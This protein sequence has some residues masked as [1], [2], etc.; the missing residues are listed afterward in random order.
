MIVTVIVLVLFCMLSA[1]QS[2]LSNGWSEFYCSGDLCVKYKASDRETFCRICNFEASYKKID[3][4][5][6][7]AVVPTKDSKCELVLNSVV[8]AES[9]RLERR[10]DLVV[11]E[12]KNFVGR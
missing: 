10:Y 7:V 8:Q 11:V 5:L 4:V 3:S 2:V 12:K 9:K 6:V 1:A